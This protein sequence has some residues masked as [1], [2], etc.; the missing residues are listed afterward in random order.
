[1]SVEDHGDDDINDIDIDLDASYVNHLHH[2]HRRRRELPFFDLRR[3]RSSVRPLHTPRPRSGPGP[4]PGS[5][6]LADSS[7]AQQP[8]LESTH[9]LSHREAASGTRVAQV[10]PP[11]IITSSSGGRRSTPH[12][13]GREGGE[14]GEGKQGVGVVSPRRHELLIDDEEDYDGGGLGGSGGPYQS[15]IKVCQSVSS[16]SRT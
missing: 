7:P 4:L 16:P 9:P 2:H 10:R 13:P 14:E 15:T 3:S 5:G 1:M 12:Q 11:M 6:P 8:G